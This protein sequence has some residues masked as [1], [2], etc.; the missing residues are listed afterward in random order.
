MHTLSIRWSEPV[1]GTHL[2]SQPRNP[3]LRRRC[4]HLAAPR[5]RPLSTPRNVPLLIRK[6]ALRIVTLS[7]RSRTRLLLRTLAPPV[8]PLTRLGL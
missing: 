3:R 8:Q 4:S 6:R 5:I 1:G 2:L 7:L